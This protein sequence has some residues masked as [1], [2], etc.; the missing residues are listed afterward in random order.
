MREFFKRCNDPTC[1]I[2][3]KRDDDTEQCNDPE[4]TVRKE[5]NLPPSLAW[6]FGQPQAFNLRLCTQFHIHSRGNVTSKTAQP[7]SNPKPKTSTVHSNNESPTPP[8]TKQTSY[9]ATVF[10]LPCLENRARTMCDLC[11]ISQ[12]LSYLHE[13]FESPTHWFNQT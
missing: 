9:Q 11:C 13:S 3:T 8:R 2:E 5:K 7:T 1:L 4:G 6:I 12:I 10:F